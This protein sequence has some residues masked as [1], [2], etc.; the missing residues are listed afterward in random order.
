[1]DIRDLRYFESVAR[2]KKFV[3]ASKELHITQ[4][5]L[6]NAIK[7]LE[8]EIGF[9]LFERSTKELSLT[10]S[11]EVF[12]QHA[13]RLL[14]QFDHIVAELGDIQA[15][16]N[17]VLKIG[18][19]ESF[20]FWIP[21]IILHFKEK[22]PS[23]NIQV[24]KMNPLEIEQALANYRIHIGITSKKEINSLTTYIPILQDP[25]SVVVPKT[26][27]FKQRESIDIIDLK[28]EKLIHSMLGYKIRETFVDSCIANGFEPKIQ[29]ETE[30][31]ETACNFVENELGIAIIPHS[32]L[33]FRDSNNLHIIPMSQLDKRTIHLAYQTERYLPQ[34][35]HYFIQLVQDVVNEAK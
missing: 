3:L 31:L 8:E 35:I 20:D 32:Y 17:G 10:E 2:N 12:L 16:G 11:G 1:M 34:A 26:H 24:K 13:E 25:L 28:G 27:R 33:K 5:S 30:S 6:S 9:K 18:A 7:K 15:V 21:K 23:M 19:I 29:Y 14:H 22:F 4:P